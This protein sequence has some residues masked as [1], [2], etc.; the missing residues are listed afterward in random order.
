LFKSREVDENNLIYGAE[1]ARILG[2]CKATFDKRVLGGRYKLACKRCKIGFKYSMFS[3]S[4]I[5]GRLTTK[6]KRLLESL[7]TRET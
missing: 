3:K 5:Q 2:I 1:A 7:G 6:L 4:H